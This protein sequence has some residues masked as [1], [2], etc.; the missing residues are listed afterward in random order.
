MGS[1]MCIRDRTFTSHFYGAKRTVGYV[2]FDS[3]SLVTGKLFEDIREAVHD[4][5]ETETNDA[6][7]VINLCVPTA[8][9]VPLDLLPKE[10]NGVRIVGIDV[11]GFGVPTHAEAKDVLAGA[12]LEYARSEIQAGPVA[13]PIQTESQRDKAT[14]ALVG[15]MF[16]VDAITI[17]R[18]LDSLGAAAGPVVPTREWRELYAALDCKAAAMIHPFYAATARQFRAAGRPLLGSAP[19]GVEGTAAWLEAMGELLGTDRA[20]IEAA[21]S[22]QKSAIRAALDNNPIC[23]LY[24]SPS[25]RDPT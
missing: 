5:A 8:S 16:P 21:I 1:E 23:L 9:G 19:V 12:M 7:I 14:V 4:L 13:R 24:T 20:S 17:D 25:P 18:L 10:I 3:E 2:P 22:T 15:E 6:V 11:P